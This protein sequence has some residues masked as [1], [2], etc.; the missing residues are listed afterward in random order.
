MDVDVDVDVGTGS[1]DGCCEWGRSELGSRNKYTCVRRM[2][3]PG[4]SRMR[5]AVL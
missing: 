2:E 5:S 1:R 4:E 3:G